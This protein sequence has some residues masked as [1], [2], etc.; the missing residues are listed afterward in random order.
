M[1]SPEEKS[2]APAPPP[3]LVQL[4]N[5]KG[6]KV[7][8]LPE[9]RMDYIAK[10]YDDQP[11]EQPMGFGEGALARTEAF[12]KGTS[13]GLSGPAADAAVG[14]ASSLSGYQGPRAAAPGL[15]GAPAE[16]SPFRQ[17]MA[18]AALARQGR[19]ENLG[20]EGLAWELAGGLA[21]MLATGGGS[22]AAKALT[23]APAALAERVGTR[24]A[25]KVIGDEA[26]ATALN[27]VAGRAAGAAVEGGIGSALGVASEKV[28]TAL[29]DPSQAA[30]DIALGTLFG[31]G[32]S[33]V[34]GSGFGLVEG[35][36]RAAHK[37]VP[38]LG[39]SIARAVEPTPPVP[40][41]RDVTPDA[42]VA[43]AVTRPL[44]AAQLPD[45]QRSL[46]KTLSDQHHALTGGAE[47][48]VEEGSRAATESLTK[49]RDL[50]DRSWV[51]HGIAQKRIVNDAATQAGWASD[52]TD[53]IDEQDAA[54]ML[55]QHAAMSATREAAEATGTAVSHARTVASTAQD[56]EAA[57]RAALDA[58]EAAGSK[59]KD[60]RPYREALSQASREARVATKELTKHEA[61]HAVTDAAHRAGVIDTSDIVPNLK[62]SR[63]LGN[64]VRADTF[65]L[66]G[67]GT[68]QID[69]GDVPGFATIA[70]IQVDPSLGRQGIGTKLYA[71]ADEFARSKGM[72]LASDLERAP[73]A[74]SW[75]KKQVDAGNARFDD[76]MGRYVL[77][78]PLRAETFVPRKLTS[79]EV[80]S[81][82]MFSGLLDGINNFKKQVAGPDLKAAQQLEKQVKSYQKI[83]YDAMRK[84]DYGSAYN[85]MDQGVKRAIS[86]MVNGAPSGAAERF[87]IEVFK[88]PQS[89]LENRK[90]WQQLA[91]NQIATNPKASAALTASAD[92]G[93]KSLYRTD[94]VMHAKEWGNR[95]AANSASVNSLVR[96]LGTQSAESVEVGTR[97]AIRAQLDDIATRAKV[98]GGGDTRIA[99][100]AAR[101]GTHVEDIFDHTALKTRDLAKAK[102]FVESGQS[103]ATAGALAG[104]VLGAPAIG[105]P[106]VAARW[107]LGSVSK[108]RGN[109][110]DKVIRG[111]TRL[112][113]VSTAASS[114][115]GKAGNRM[116][117]TQLRTEARKDALNDARETLDLTSKKFGALAREAEAT[118]LVSPGLGDEILKST[119]ARADYIHSKLPKPPSAAVFSP[120]PRLC[121]AAARSLDRAIQATQSPAKTF[122]RMLNG[123]AT[124]EDMDAMR[125][126]YPQAYSTMV[127]QIM[128]E[129]SKNP[130]RPRSTQSKMYLSRL[131]GQ[132]LTP[133]LMNI[134]DAQRRAKAAT[135]GAA[136]AGKPQGQG[137]NGSD[138]KTFRAKMT[139]KPDDVY[140]SRA[141]RVMTED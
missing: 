48:A 34:L 62:F 120:Q 113:E 43:E 19:A 92:A 2:P 141:D 110:L 106:F 86:E 74:E 71:K 111:T 60:L 33:A 100:E 104:A 16:G 114:K 73:A 85:A 49:L 11:A 96:Q 135:A 72:K 1:A 108:Y 116:V 12:A 118:N 129:I 87:G 128:D 53:V 90:V 13:L 95:M 63:D 10:G 46:A 45:P 112:L 123:A 55:E 76:E 88:V 69:S 32:A 6:E 125:K 40:V 23:M 64:G 21:P 126:L 38:D 47:Q 109:L 131:V 124:P 138:G 103:L 127:N 5:D 97:R 98:W 57:A 136:D 137:A 94:G 14:L 4:T 39:A 30:E 102:A 121:I 91:E 58:A 133:A 119:L 89:F 70:K 83:A 24:V 107:L 44:T 37:A 31:T 59:G 17:A 29:Q 27:Y 35:L 101:L 54:H 36:S 132:P 77:E 25:A 41:V 52:L 8:V 18:E 50:Y 15:D 130:Q 61:A 139:L 65:D 79:V 117:S 26:A 3:A 115:L 7:N 75:W 68:V 140:G 20:G 9:E 56:A 82:G 42:A 81:R 105:M 66:P 67:K 93:Y 28:E 51:E 78:Q 84:G 122:D 22:L 99:D 80:E 134:V